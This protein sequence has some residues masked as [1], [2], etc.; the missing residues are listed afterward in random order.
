MTSGQ[1]PLRGREHDVAGADVFH[2]NR[3]RANRV[4]LSVKLR[5]R[6]RD[7]PAPHPARER[8][9]SESRYLD[10]HEYPAFMREMVEIH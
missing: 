9:V 5:N 6:T 7:A 1:A 10:V 8:Q 4:R 2:D 3:S